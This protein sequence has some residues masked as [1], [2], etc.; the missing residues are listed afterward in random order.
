MCP[1]VCAHLGVA[2][3]VDF[4]LNLLLLGAIAL[5]S[6][7]IGV[8]FLRFWRAGRDRFFLFFALSFFVQA[9]NRVALALSESPNEGAGWHYWVRLVAYL[10][11]LVAIIDKN[12][13]S[14]RSDSR[15]STPPVRPL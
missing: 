13:P 12:W 15:G 7:T 4:Q 9:A 10:L 11:I 6:F 3:A 8:F 5:G 2:L 14:P 1:P